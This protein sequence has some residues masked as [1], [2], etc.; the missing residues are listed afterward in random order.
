MWVFLS[1]NSPGCWAALHQKSCWGGVH[2]PLFSWF[3]DTSSSV[4]LKL[5][6]AG[7]PFVELVKCWFWLSHGSKFLHFWQGLRVMR[8]GG[9]LFELPG[10]GQYREAWVQGFKSH[11][12]KWHPHHC[13][14]FISKMLA[15]W[16]HL[17]QGSPENRCLV[18]GH[19]PYIL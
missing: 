5:L 10:R 11:A 14:C 17:V 8:L 16:P 7:G 1:W 6:Q 4:F 12:C 13:S 18:S 15:V 2:G 9:Q 19:G 3:P